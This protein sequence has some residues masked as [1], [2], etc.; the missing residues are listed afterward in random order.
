MKAASLKELKEELKTLHPSK[1][2]DLCMHLVKYK[3]ENKELL[4]YLLFEVG[5]E[6]SY[7]K[8]IKIQIEEEFENV[9]KSN[10]YLAKK[11]IRKI[12]RITNKYIKYSG[13]KQTEVVLLIHFCKKIKESNLSLKANSVLGNLYQRQVIRIE[14]ALATLH[15]DLQYDYAEEIMLLK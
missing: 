3:K 12:L 5:D 6:Q 14:K 8:E 4:S 9:N 11:T 7:I 15:E 10:L 13:V 1:M 2:L